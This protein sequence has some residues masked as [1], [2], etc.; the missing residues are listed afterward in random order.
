MRD[1]QSHAMDHRKNR[2]HVIGAPLLRANNLGLS[3]RDV[4]RRA[5]QAARC[6]MLA[7]CTDGHRPDVKAPLVSMAPRWNELAEKM[8][9]FAE[10]VTPSG[11]S[12]ES[13][14]K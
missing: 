11:G 13:D 1:L 12:R 6:G 9:R 5:L 8:D 3:F 7:G 4:S 10:T 2:R 14:R